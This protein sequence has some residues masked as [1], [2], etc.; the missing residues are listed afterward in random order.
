MCYII[1]IVVDVA[2]QRT[3]IEIKRPSVLSLGLFL[4]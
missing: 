2:I 4:A 1:G 3:Q